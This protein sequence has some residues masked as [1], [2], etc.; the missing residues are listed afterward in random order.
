MTLGERRW[1][2]ERPVISSHR[3]RTIGFSRAG[4]RARSRLLARR[5]ARERWAP[6]AW[7]NAH[8]FGCSRVL[9]EPASRRSVTWTG[10]RRPGP[11]LCRPLRASPRIQNVSGR[12]PASG[13]TPRANTRSTQISA[14]QELRTNWLGNTV[15]RPTK[16][17]LWS[18]RPF[19]RST[20][21]RSANRAHEQ[22]RQWRTS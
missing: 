5:R 8:V 6:L 16:G 12:P 15:A 4:E 10:R 9:P 20:G 1:A 7:D 2:Q 11:R 19:L 18:R 17:R 21:N 14:Y 13:G 22:E 3:P